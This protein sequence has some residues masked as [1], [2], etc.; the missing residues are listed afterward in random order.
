MFKGAIHEENMN[1][2][3][4]CIKFNGTAFIKPWIAGDVITNRNALVVEGLITSVNNR[5]R[6]QKKK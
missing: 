1:N 3:Y 2:L 6:R 4:P 5:S